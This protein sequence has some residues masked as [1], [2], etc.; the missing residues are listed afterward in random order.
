[1]LLRF[2]EKVSNSENQDIWVVENLAEVIGDELEKGVGSQ[3]QKNKL[4]FASS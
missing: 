2:F 4:I 1:M 3:V